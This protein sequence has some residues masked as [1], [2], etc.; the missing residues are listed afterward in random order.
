M[1]DDPSEQ[2]I[3]DAVQKLR[4]SESRDE[5]E[6]AAVAL[7]QGDDP[8]FL[9][10]LAPFLGDPS[11]LARLD[12]LS[13]PQTKLAHLRKVM[14]VLAKAPSPEVEAIGLS[15]AD[16]EAFLAEEDRRLLILTTLAAVRP[17]SEAGSAVFEM[18]NAL[19]YFAINAPLLVK[20]GSPRALALFEEMMKDREV[21]ADR[22]VDCLH[23][24]VLPHR[25][26]LP[27]L[28]MLDRLL[29]A[30]LEPPVATGV[31]ESLFDYRARE[32]FGHHPPLP[33][34]LRS[35]PREVLEFYLQLGRKA[36]EQ[37]GLNPRL[38]TVVEGVLRT[39]SALL[40]RRRA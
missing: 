12:D 9:D 39:V 25:T 14:S 38:R 31:I 7:A 6:A 32:W 30:R 16:N 28:Q 34:P 36:L 15:L 35:A 3:A 5:L 10:A 24:A 37:P 29:S 17:M 19:G 1:A 2:I 23:T 21:P 11:F 26:D 40:A 18:A 27:V 8:R 4:S 22:R 13:D 33:P 20:N